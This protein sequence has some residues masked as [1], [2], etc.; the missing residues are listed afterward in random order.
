MPGPF[1]PMYPQVKCTLQTDCFLYGEGVCA[2]VPA[3]PLSS[4]GST[5]MA[6]STSLR[7]AGNNDIAKDS[8]AAV[9]KTNCSVPNNH[10]N[11]LYNPIV[12]LPQHI[13]FQNAI[14]CCLTWICLMTSQCK[15]CLFATRCFVFI[16]PLGEKIEKLCFWLRVLGFQELSTISSL[17]TYFKVVLLS[18][19]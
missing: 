18:R 19:H 13:S 14:F 3:S 15:C 12:F 6:S 5:P 17:D 8:K 7:K 1:L 11:I 2:S 16:S 4:Q 10:I 9:S